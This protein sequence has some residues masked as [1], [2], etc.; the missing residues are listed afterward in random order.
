MYDINFKN[1]K[2]YY[3]KGKGG[4]KKSL[5]FKLYQEL[6]KVYLQGKNLIGL[7]VNKNFKAEL[8]IVNKTGY[9]PRGL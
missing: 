6:W 3:L 2:Y 9:A 7:V 4:A 8:L 5:K 1:V